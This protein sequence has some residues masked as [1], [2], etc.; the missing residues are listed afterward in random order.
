MDT[1][2]SVNTLWFFQYIKTPSE[3]KNGKKVSSSFFSVRIN[4][5]NNNLLVLGG[6]NLMRMVIK[7]F[8]KKSAVF[9]QN[10]KKS[11]HWQKIIKIGNCIQYVKPERY[12]RTKFQVSHIKTASKRTQWKVPAAKWQK[13]INFDIH[14]KDKYML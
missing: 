5:K 4:R 2:S 9:L 6:Y 1:T 12:L 3:V 14:I 7:N 8:K 13:N 10:G 11:K